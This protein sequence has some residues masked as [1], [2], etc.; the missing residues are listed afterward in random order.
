ME[1]SLI[2]SREDPFGKFLISSKV[3]LNVCFFIEIIIIM[4]WCIWSIR[5]DAIFRSIGES[6]QR[7]LEMFRSV[8]GLLLWRAKK[9]YFPQIEIWLEQLV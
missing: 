6:S 9:K 8:F 4:S 7:C 5:N 2:T 1:S 3:W